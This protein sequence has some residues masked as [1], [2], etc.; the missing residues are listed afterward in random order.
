MSTLHVPHIRCTL[1]TNNVNRKGFLYA[2]KD[3]LLTCVM[4]M[5]AGGFFVTNFL[6]LAGTSMTPIPG[7][8]MA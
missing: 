3:L 2:G 5:S 4:C 7:Y 8:E 6:C 1:A